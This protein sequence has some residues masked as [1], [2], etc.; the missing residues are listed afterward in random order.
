MEH[1]ERH[2]SPMRTTHPQTNGTTGP[3]GET[4]AATGT[5]ACPHCHAPYRKW[6]DAWVVLKLRRLRVEPGT[7]RYQLQCRRCRRWFTGPTRMTRRAP[8]GSPPAVRVA[9]EPKAHSPPPGR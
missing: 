3:R 5:G 2:L 7:G 4:T 1:Q 8:E 9:A 6:R